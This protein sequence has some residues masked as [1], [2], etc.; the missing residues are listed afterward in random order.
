[1]QQRL[2]QFLSAENISRAQFAD[3]IGVARASI[4]HIM[5]GRNKPSYEFMVNIMDRFPNL[6]IE[7]LL[8]GRGKMYKNDAE[9]TRHEPYGDLFDSHEE[10]LAPEPVQDF[11]NEEVIAVES[12]K[13]A[14]VKKIVI[15]YN[16]GTYQ[17]FC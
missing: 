4:S 5:A 12:P 1:M 2:E 16:D 3:I 10:E 15:L 8:K 13:S 17:E 9:P 11:E 6:N 14:R 7:W